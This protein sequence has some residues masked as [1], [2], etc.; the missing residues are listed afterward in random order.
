CVVGVENPFNVGWLSTKCAGLVGR[1]LQSLVGRPIDVQFVVE[2]REPEPIDPPPLTLSAPPRGAGRTRAAARR[3]PAAP[4]PAISPRY[5]F[6][7]F[8]VGKNNQFAHAA[9][10]AAAQQPGQ[11]HNP[12]FIYGG[13]GLGKTHLL[14]AIAHAGLARGLEV[15]YV[16]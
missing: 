13:V 2:R 1:T 8:V 3:A 12:L 6:D 4:R 15:V 7:S 16:S 11:V 5:T 9:C 14:Y 10:V